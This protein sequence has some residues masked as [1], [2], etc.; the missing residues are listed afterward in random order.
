MEKSLLGAL[1]AASNTWLKL[2]NKRQLLSIEIF[3]PRLFKVTN[4]SIKEGQETD[5]P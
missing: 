4:Y 1:P 3:E 5:D 2:N